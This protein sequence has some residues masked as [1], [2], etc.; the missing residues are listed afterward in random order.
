MK[1]CSRCR[2]VKGLLEFYLVKNKPGS[3]CKACHNE[4]IKKYTNSQE[5]RQKI[6]ERQAAKYLKT[7]ADPTSAKAR[8]NKAR[9]AAALRR[10]H[11]PDVRAAEAERMRLWRLREP[12]AALLRG[13]RARAIRD[14]IPFNLTVEWA[15]NRYTGYCELT[16]LKFEPGEGKINSRSPSIDRVN[17]IEGYVIGNCRFIC[18]AINSFRGSHADNEM[19]FLA[20]KLIEKRDFT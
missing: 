1:S 11:R 6:K 4:V 10:Y 8:R 14:E 2:S 17:P 15:K 20:T 9:A 5:G 16:G 13:V 18:S 3:W 7:M 12:A 19:Y